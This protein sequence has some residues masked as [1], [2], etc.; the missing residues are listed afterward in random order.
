MNMREQENR[1]HIS[2][3]LLVD[4]RRKN[5]FSLET[6]LNTFDARIYKAQ[7]GKE[8]LS[9]LV[10]HRFALALLD[11]QMPGM[12]GFELAELIRNNKETRNI[13]IIFVTAISKDQE[14]VFKGY[15][16][17]A[18]D[19]L[20]KPLNPEILK[21]KVRVFLI[22]DQQKR[23]L[24][25]TAGELSNANRK[26]Q[27]AKDDLEL[28]VRERTADLTVANERLREEIHE[29]IQTE[30]KLK[31][32][33]KEAD[34]ANRAKSEFLANMSHEIRTPLNAV[35]GFSELLSSLVADAKH[36]SYVDAIKTA[37]KSLLTLINDILDLSKIE[38]EM[39]EIQYEPVNVQL[40]FN[41]I[42]KIFK[43]K[44]DGKKLQ[45]HIEIDEDLPPGL[46]LDETRL[47]QILFNLVG[48]A[49]KF[50]EEGRITMTAKKGG[51]ISPRG[52]VDVTIS[53]EDTGMGIPE[54]ERGCIFESFKQQHGQSTRKFGGTG[55][56]LAI[57]KKLVEIMNG[58][59]SVRSEVGVGS[60]FEVTFRDVAGA[61]SERPAPR[62]KE[63]GIEN[64]F[65]EKAKVLVVDDVESNRA[66]IRELLSRV[67]LDVLTAE[68][69][70]EAVLL[71]REYQPDLIIMDIRMPVMDGYE[72]LKRIR[73]NPD[74]KEIPIIALT[75]SVESGDIA[76]RI[77]AGFDER[78]TKPVMMRRLLSKLSRFLAHTKIAE[79]AGAGS[80]R[81]DAPRKLTME[82]MERLPE[83]L[84]T[85]RADMT[86]R[87]NKIKQ[88]MK[89]S[90]IRTFEESLRGL[91]VEY[92]VN[93]LIDYADQLNRHGRTFDIGSLEKCLGLFPG[94]VEELAGLIDEREEP[95]E[96]TSSR[97]RSK[98]KAP[99]PGR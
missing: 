41:E 22:L 31:K 37:G 54:E 47:R 53:V 46:M 16:A 79:A 18:V 24:E 42:E 95:P 68:N 84:E 43:M 56:G 97:F 89:V 38:A 75:A 90:D 9:L 25:Q 92:K 14:H 36:K 60:A 83:L 57:S 88:V 4:D 33:K 29:R 34:A 52:S 70:Q 98:R 2:K 40:L 73:E 77:D 12:D 35:T 59:I 76:K 3:I 66:L 55:L 81:D 96:S 63:L 51:A 49:V 27:K 94:M 78:L 99:R 44:I 91:G 17:G 93:G 7:S 67:N 20:P 58:R 48:N 69:G 71:S 1:D 87:L 64:I 13:P 45:L 15:G 82:N 62:E 39:M 80:A 19:Y 26:L 50:T 85:M 32:A 72:A 8:A 74:A 86:P 5:L 10:R 21:Q 61:S 11:V 23:L 28:R 30:E 6:L 65:F